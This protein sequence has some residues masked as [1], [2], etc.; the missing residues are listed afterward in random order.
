MEQYTRK[1][2]CPN[3]GCTRSLNI[4]WDVNKGFKNTRCPACKALFEPYI[5]IIIKF[6]K[7]S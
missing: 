6:T 4:Q 5:E 3:T 2:K 1:V 7:L